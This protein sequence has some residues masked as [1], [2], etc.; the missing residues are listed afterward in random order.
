MVSRVDEGGAAHAL[1]VAPGDVVTSMRAG[2]PGDDSGE[3]AI[4]VESYDQLMGLFP[5]MGR[6]VTL[7]FLT[8]KP[9][10]GVPGG[11]V[12]FKME[13]EIAKAT[14]IIGKLTTERSM[15]PDA[16][17]PQEILRKARGLAFIRVAKVGFVASVKCGSGL[18]V[19]RLGESLDS[20]SAPCAIGTAGLGFGFQ[21]GAE[22]T[23]FMLVLNTQ[24]AIEAFASGSQVRG[25]EHT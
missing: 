19:T 11:V 21:W 3:P 20:W 6:P 25:L 10:G 9:G 14:E 8:P 17:V 23:D 5:A 13:D 12:N 22:L 15:N 7:T 24:E 4:K 1:Q 16:L 18:V 2:F